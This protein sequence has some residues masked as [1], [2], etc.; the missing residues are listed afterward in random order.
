VQLGIK[1]GFAVSYMQGFS[2]DDGVIDKELSY[3][4]YLE[5]KKLI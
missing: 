2:V 4:Q 1:K 5:S 3:V